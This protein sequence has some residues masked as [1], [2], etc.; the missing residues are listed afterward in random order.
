MTERLDARLSN[1]H[2]VTLSRQWLGTGGEKGA[3]MVRGSKEHLSREDAESMRRREAAGV[4]GGEPN[5]AAFLAA[6]DEK[7]AVDHDA[8][9]RREAE[10]ELRKDGLPE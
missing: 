4:P 9:R 5:G 7:E 2:R 1:C 6:S 3:L 8:V 10:R